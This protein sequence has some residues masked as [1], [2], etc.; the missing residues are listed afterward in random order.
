MNDRSPCCVA[1]Y[2]LFALQ[3]KTHCGRIQQNLVTYG[4]GSSRSNDLNSAMAGPGWRTAETARHFRS[5]VD[6]FG[7]A[8]CVFEFDA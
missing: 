4:L 3:Q 8:Q 1:T 2:V 5:E 6:L 7:D